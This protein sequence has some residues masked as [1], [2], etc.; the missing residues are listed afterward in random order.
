MIEKITYGT[1]WGLIYMPKGYND[2][3]GRIYL[4]AQ[5]EQSSSAYLC[6]KMCVCVWLCVSV[7]YALD[8]SLASA[9]WP[10]H[11][12]VSRSSHSICINIL[13][14]IPYGNPLTAPLRGNAHFNPCSWWWPAIPS[15]QSLDGQIAITTS[16]T[17]M[18]HLA[19]STQQ[20]V[21]HEC[22]IY[23]ANPAVI[24]AVLMIARPSKQ[25]KSPHGSGLF[26]TSITYYEI[27]LFQAKK[28]LRA[29]RNAISIL[30]SRK[31]EK[32]FHFTIHST[33]HIL[34]QRG[35]WMTFLSSMTI[36]VI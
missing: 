28:A 16:L 27:D 14:A 19:R 17:D 5:G 32:R 25:M 12:W 7:C 22:N 2:L 24:N 34:R 36:D 10:Y 11:C 29:W 4:L 30:L 3:A 23:E 9:N 15:I 26:C 18:M 31:H 6:I 21:M 13:A 35:H 1:L 33:W 8:L 20:P